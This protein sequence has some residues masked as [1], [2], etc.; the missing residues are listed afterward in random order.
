ML[1]TI[2][3]VSPKTILPYQKLVTLSL[4]ILLLITALAGIGCA[5]SPRAEVRIGYLLGDLHHLPFFVALE[6]GFFTDEGIN[7]KAVGPFDA[8]TSEMNA[9]AAGQIDMGYVGTAP[10]VIA[11][12]RGI[13]LSIVA[14]VNAEGSALI[15]DDTIDDVSGLRGKKIAT[16]LPGSIQY[17]MLA[18][19]LAKNNMSFEELEVLPGTIKPPDMPAALETRSINGYI[20]WE[21][22]AAKSVVAGVG[23]VLVESA[24]I[25]PGH[26]CCVV[27]TGT[28]F[29][30][31]SPKAVEG[32]IRAHKRAITFIKENPEEAKLIAAE[33]TKLDVKTIEEALRRVK[34]DYNV[35]VVATK[36]FVEEIISLGEAG[37]IKPIIRSGEV[38]NI[39]AFISKT[40][41]LSFLKEK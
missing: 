27:V 18:M 12:V 6:K 3:R 16:P 11:A 38:P 39:D 30:E 25:W 4:V 34:F 8:G 32:V 14:G 10:A 23:K 1:V 20:V 41:N 33:Y 13:G 35:N 5:A 22:Y 24:D 9:L 15:T 40:I 2:Y 29:A 26:P 37:I 28:D 36:R 19:L 21:P 31:Q 17:V 7:V